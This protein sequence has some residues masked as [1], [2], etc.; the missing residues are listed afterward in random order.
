MEKQNLNSHKVSKSLKEVNGLFRMI[1]E[2]RAEG[3]GEIRM[4]LLQ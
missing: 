4:H 1:E 3:A 2:S